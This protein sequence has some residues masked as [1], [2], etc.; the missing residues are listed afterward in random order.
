MKKCFL[1]CPIGDEGSEIRRTSDVVLKYIVAPVC[2]ECGYEI[3]RSDTEFTANSIN[4]DIFNHLDNDELAIA[5]LSGLNPNVFYEAGYRKAKGLPLIHIAREGTVLPF[6]IKTIRTYF[7]G[8]EA[9]KVDNAKEALKKV[10]SNIQGKNK[11][12]I[13]EKSSEVLLSEKM[14]VELSNVYKLPVDKG[15]D[16]ILKINIYNNF[17]STLFVQNIEVGKANVTLPLSKERL[18]LITSVSRK[19]GVET[20]RKALI[21][22]PIPFKV[23]PEDFV[24]GYFELFDKDNNINICENDIITLRVN[25]GKMVYEKDYVIS[26]IDSWEDINF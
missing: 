13:A 18:E 15:Y 2:E 8:I 17:V 11:D 19:N 5:D 23:F 3:I 1:I 4:D 14:N 12:N 24:S 9:D 22:Q 16:Y 20:G 25:V 21:S 6:D 10:I 26:K 7:Y